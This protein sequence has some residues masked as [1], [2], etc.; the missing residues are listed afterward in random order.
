MATPS[1]SQRALAA[2]EMPEREKDEHRGRNRLVT[3]DDVG[4]ALRWLAENAADLGHAR[5]RLIKSGHMIKHVEALLF[6]ASGEKTVD[7]KKA[8]VRASRKWLDAIDEEAAA[9]GDFEKMKALREAASARIECW[10]SESATLR[11][12]RP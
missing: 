7:A 3:D 8:A 4:N 10:R 5:A 9:A 1:I 6:L 2:S 12:S 11:G